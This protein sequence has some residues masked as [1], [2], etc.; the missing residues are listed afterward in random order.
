MMRA[1]QV[2]IH[3][4]EIPTH[5]YLIVKGFA[6]RYKLLDD[7]RRQILGY[8]IPGD[9]CEIDLPPGALPDHCVAALNAATVAVISMTGLAALRSEH[10]N[11]DRL[12]SLI[13]LTD[14]SILR[15][16]LM[17]IGQRN[18]IQRIGHFFCEIRARMEAIGEL[19]PDGSIDLPLT[20]AVLADTTGLT[21]VHVNRSLK[22]LRKEGLVALRG[23]R[24]SILDRGRLEEMAAFNQ[25]YL[26]LAG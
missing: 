11:I 19:A 26:R 14:R 7:G 21:T 2:L 15:E 24:L 8:L 13:A 18:A 1:E 12:C 17:N 22:K 3:D 10:P 4:G 23:H 20:Q 9:L 16:W 6:Y 5:A 25:D